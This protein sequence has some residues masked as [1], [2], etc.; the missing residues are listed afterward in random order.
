MREEE[1]ATVYAQDP[2]AR[3]DATHRLARETSRLWLR[4]A[5]R[6]L[7]IE[8][9]ELWAS[10]EARAVSQLNSGT[11]AL[12]MSAKRIAPFRQLLKS[13]GLPLHHACIARGERAA[14]QRALAIASANA[15]LAA[16]LR[17]QQNGCFTPQKAAL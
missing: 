10:E 14:R 3:A 12:Y 17:E 16:F 9:P 8:Q 11:R 1:I 4:W 15:A 2:K 13:V 5:M 7:L 6:G